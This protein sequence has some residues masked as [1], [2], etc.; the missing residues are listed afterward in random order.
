MEAIKI[1]WLFWEF[2]LLSVG[3]EFSGVSIDYNFLNSND[4]VL[5]RAISSQKVVNFN[6]EWN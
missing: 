5:N 6:M 3:I 1:S 4:T 2:P